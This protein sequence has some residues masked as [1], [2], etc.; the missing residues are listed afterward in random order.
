MRPVTLMAGLVALV[1]LAVVLFGVR[2]VETS[3]QTEA[4]AS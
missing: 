4:A 2:E 1:A 3:G